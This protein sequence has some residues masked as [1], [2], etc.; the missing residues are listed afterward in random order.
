MRSFAI[1]V[2]AISLLAVSCDT[3]EHDFAIAAVSFTMD[4]KPEDYWASASSAPILAYH[5]ELLYRGDIAATD[6]EFARVYL[7][8]TTSQWWTIDPLD[9]FDPVGKTIGDMSTSHYSDDNV[10]ELP[11]GELV[12]EV[13]LTDGTVSRY[14]FTM[15][16]PGATTTGGYAYAYAADDG[17][18]PT[19]PSLSVP[20]LRRAAVTGLATDTDDGT[21]TVGFTVNGPNANNGYVWLYDSAGDFMGASPWFR[22]PSTGAYASSVNGGAGFANADGAANTVV[23]S[24][25][26]ITADGAAI[27]DAAFA[28]IAH[29]RVVL[30]DGAQYAS[31]GYGNYDYRSVSSLF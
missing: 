13:A 5:F 14:A 20:A 7:P 30:T 15:G 26:Q 24:A 28:A 3:G 19:Y 25:P 6:I 17:L 21:I 12:A 8:G 11:I 1:I 10:R 22:D 16:Q 4:N 29:C 31:M 18:S 2:V 23:L 9:Y 27:S